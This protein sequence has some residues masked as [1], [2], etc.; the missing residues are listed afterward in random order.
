MILTDFIV[1]D[2]RPILLVLL[3]GAGLLLVI[4]SVNVAHPGFGSPANL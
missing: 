1:G 3:S 2:I 4:A